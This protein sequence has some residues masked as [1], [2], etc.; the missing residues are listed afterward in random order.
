MINLF[1]QTLRTQFSGTYIPHRK[2]SA[3]AFG[4]LKDVKLVPYLSF[5]VSLI[6]AL[7]IAGRYAIAEQR[8]LKTGQ[9]DKLDA[10]LLL[11]GSGSMLSTDPLRLR[12]QGAKLFLQFL[13]QGDKLSIIEFSQ[14]ARVIRTLEDYSPDKAGEVEQSISSVSTSGEY[15]NILAGVKAAASILE[16]NGRQ[17]S[18]KVIIVLSDGKMDPD[19]TAGDPKLLTEELLNDILP[20]LKQKN[21]KIHTL[22]FSEQADKDLLSQVAVGTDGVNWF[23]PSA[24]KVHESFADLFLV[25]K[26]PQVL[27][28][29]KKGFEIDEDIEEATFYVNAEEGNEIVLISPSNLTLSIGSKPDSVKWFKGQKFDVITL[30][31]P[32]PGTWQLR[33]ISGNEGFA[34][35]LTNL[36]LVADWPETVYAGD[37]T[38]IQARLYEG[39]KPIVLPAMSGVVNYAFQITPTDKVSEPIARDRLLDD[40][41]QGDVV[42]DD[43]IFSA[44]V[45]IPSEG[46]YRLRILA[47]APTFEREQNVPFRVRPPVISIHIRHGGEGHGSESGHENEGHE[48]QETVDHPPSHEDHGH[49]NEDNDHHD[50]EG[51]SATPDKDTSHEGIT[52][53]QNS[54]SIEITLSP[55][56]AGYKGLEVS[57]TAI[58][59]DRTILAIPLAR[60]GEHGGYVAPASLLPAGGPYEL[61]ASLSGKNKKGATV[62]AASNPLQ[63]DYFDDKG[64]EKPVVEVKI[65][66]KPIENEEFPWISLLLVTGINVIVG[67]AFWFLLKKTQTESTSIITAYE[68][69]PEIHTFIESL[70]K[71]IDSNQV[72]IDDPLFSKIPVAREVHPTEEAEPPAEEEAVIEEGQDNV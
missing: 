32:D 60:G 67:A 2:R 30:K 34:T 14:G 51:H 54:D 37:T 59:E 23:T 63:I 68:P 26:K 71:K 4:T 44:T 3:I 12:D 43:G 55:E 53:V 17:D 22:S 47:R 57:L 62:K 25:I 27:P 24:D 42:K 52:K 50:E 1:D 41:T 29:T 5:L 8:E 38:L 13:R 33:G 35:V 18:N 66:E 58:N 9:T 7:I 56:V 20:D 10:V 48:A 16:K 65:P 72:N 61:K 49:K 21:I 6:L 45:K 31:K 70:R 64:R 36:K 69:P 39:E 11:D 40:G 15:T 28:L 46:E 19:P